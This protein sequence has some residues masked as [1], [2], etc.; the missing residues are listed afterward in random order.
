MRAGGEEFGGTSQ[1]LGDA[2]VGVGAGEGV[3]QQPVAALGEGGCR[4]QGWGVEGIRD[5]QGAASEQFPY[6]AVRIVPARRGQG[7]VLVGVF[8]PERAQHEDRPALRGDQQVVHGRCDL[9]TDRPVP[10]VVL[11]LVQPD[12]GARLDLV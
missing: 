2:P 10:D 5:G 7:R 6:P 4:G 1:V 3:G 8:G 9:L 12:D 11:G